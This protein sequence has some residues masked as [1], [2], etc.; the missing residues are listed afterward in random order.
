MLITALGASGVAA[1]AL[2]TL[3]SGRVRVPVRSSRHGE[4]FSLTEDQ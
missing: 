4:N 3:S 2:A 1:V